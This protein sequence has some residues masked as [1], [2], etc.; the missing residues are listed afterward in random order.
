[1]YKNGA[2]H[3]K[4][5]CKQL[6][7]LRFVNYIHGEITVTFNK[8]P[9]IQL[10]VATL[11]QHNKMADPIFPLSSFCPGAR[12]ASFPSNVTNMNHYFLTT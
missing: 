9:L 6:Q 5:K 1:M 12:L 8:P 3:F 7:Q 4:D 11:H 2:E 10:A